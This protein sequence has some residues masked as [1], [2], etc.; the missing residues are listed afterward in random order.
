MDNNNGQAKKRLFIIDGSSVI[1]RAF[2]A[3]PPSFVTSGG[4]P[5]NAVYGFTQSLRKIIGDFAPDYIAIAFDVKG[6]SFRSEMFE[7]YKAHRPP[8]PDLLSV[9]IPYIKRVVRAFDIPVLEMTGFE[10]D[11]VIATLVGRA[12]S[13]GVRVSV[14]TGDKDMYQ[15]V[16]DN[17]VILDYLSGKEY[18]P[19]EVVEKFGVGPT[20][21]RDLIGLAGDSS[22]NIPGVPGVGVKTAAKL[23]RQFKDIDDMYA[24]I[25]SVK[26]D[27]LREKLKE[28][29]DKAYLSRELATLHPEV[30]IDCA[31]DGLA[32]RGPDFEALE[33]LLSELEFKKILMDML[34]GRPAKADKGE[35]EAI[36]TEKRLGELTSSLK[37]AQRAS[38]MAIMS[39]DA[40][41]GAL[42][43]IAIAIEHEKGFYIPV[44]EGK[45]ADAPDA[46]ELPIGAGG[47]DSTVV[48]AALKDFFENAGVRKDTNN[49]K[50]LYICLGSRGFEMSGVGI[51]TSLAS[52]V[53]NPSKAEHT[54]EAL[55]YEHLGETG[56]AEPKAG[57]IV[58][59]AA[60]VYGRK[61]CNILKIAEILEKLIEEAGV[62]EL[63]TGME[64]PLA[65]VLAVMEMTGIRVDGDVLSGLSK[66]MA[67]E[68]AD[69][70]RRIYAAAGEEF[71]IS[72]PK[73]L[74]ELLFDRLGLKP[75][76]RTKTGFST[77]EEVLTRLAAEHEVP[78]LIIS[79]RQLA[80]LKSTYVD[81]LIELI[82]VETGRVHTSFNQTVTATGRLSS[83][84]PNL[85]NIPVRGAFAPRIRGAFVASDG[86]RFLSADYSQ[87]ELR[88]VAHM[89][90][91]PVLVESFTKGEDVHSRTAS[92]VFGI[93]PALVTPEMR[94]RAKA[95]NFGII[96]GMGPY[97]LAAE[98][99]ISMKEALDY[100]NSYFAHYSRV[101]EFIDST[102]REA[103]ARGYTV[104]LF[105]RRRF[106][107]ELKSPV[108]STV[109][110][111]QRLA[112]NTPIQGTAADMIKA[113]MIRVA[114]ELKARKLS[115]R[116]LLQI[117]DELLMEA[118]D[119]EVEAVTQ[120]V[121]EAMEGVLK[122]T[123]PV[124]VNFKSGATWDRVE[125]RKG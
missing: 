48:L 102:V 4:L 74:S 113:A 122:L 19:A 95:I 73:Q 2:H 31:L 56:Q 5:T 91:D 105:G 125:A 90:A 84:R 1:Y 27:K 88:L 30:P 70:E 13:S 80:K 78:Q 40:F 35:F 103:E 89:S 33:P 108:E 117:H 124:V 11:D 121:K 75:V 42:Q 67:I 79:Y 32:S 107:P 23:L 3:V 69:I 8:M 51:D 39:D 54:I 55:A 106:I 66:E 17:V 34:P 15:L 64:L 76:K 26:G 92:E 38:V 87:I 50:A 85:Q 28:N 97:G 25:D 109:R 43:A 22:D 49:S 116:M 119:G 58:G 72:S 37:S 62:L 53:L 16:T 111:G 10:A 82:S 46:A 18:G 9:Q 36:T 96:Y 100:I 65:R 29:R 60:A 12:E 77:D 110:L 21:I 123:V 41:G 63:Y 104:S 112:I 101:K 118:A 44:N 47:L 59:E 14:I 93:M 6:P 83:S 57:F 71:N 120:L 45:G 99:G 86:F 81:A 98:L 52:Y 94:R 68:I 115:S 24:N 20:Q 114:G 61:A 7:E